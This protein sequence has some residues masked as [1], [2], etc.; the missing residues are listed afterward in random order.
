MRYGLL[1]SIG[2]A[3]LAV[4][5]AWIVFGG[6]PPLDARFALSDCRHVDLRDTE[7]GDLV[8]GAEDMV[9]LPDGDTLLV[10]AFDRADERRPLTGLFGVSLLDLQQGTEE[11]AVEALIKSYTL[12]GGVKPYGIAL[13][14]SGERLALINRVGPED[15]TVIDVLDWEG[16]YF[17]PTE[18]HEHEAF[19]RANDLTFDLSGNLLVTRDRAQCRLSPIDMIPYHATGIVLTLTPEGELSAGEERYMFPNGIAIGPTGSPIVAET[20]A[21]RLSGGYVDA[22]LPGGPDNLTIDDQGALIA[23][24]HPSLW[25][26]FLYVNGFAFSSP[27]RVVRADPERT[28]IEVL[29]DDPDSE[30]MSA[31]SVGVMRDGRLYMGSAIDDGIVVCE[32]R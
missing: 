25:Q 15:R 9:F 19:C 2:V 8:A 16:D 13:S 5:A 24:V 32:K 27:S 31:V 21:G 29:F 22:L 12:R 7:T 18:R 23:A 28:D 17:R 26:L 14:S 1:I 20:R 4:I 10:S 30:L 6:T 3:L 11:I